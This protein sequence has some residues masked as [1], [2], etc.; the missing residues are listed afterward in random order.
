MLIV[1]LSKLYVTNFIFKMIKKRDSIK[2][3]YIW[4]FSPMS[5]PDLC[6]WILAGQTKIMFD[7]T[8]PSEMLKNKSI[9]DRRQYS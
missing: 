1:I 8:Q 3:G 4:W 6:P 7:T 2:V 9:S 5:L